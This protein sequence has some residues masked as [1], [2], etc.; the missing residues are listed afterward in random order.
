[1]RYFLL[2]AFFLLMLMGNTQPQ[3]KEYNCISFG[4]NAKQNFSMLDSVVGNYQ[5]FLI[6]E[7]HGVSAN[8]KIVME[9][10]PYLHEK[11]N[12]R[13]LLIE[14]GYTDAYLIN[15]YLATGDSF[16]LNPLFYYRYKDY[17]NFWRELYHFNQKMPKEKRITV[18]GI[19]FEYSRP[20]AFV[21]NSLITRG[22]KIPDEILPAIT[23]IMV[24]DDSLSEIGKRKFLLHLRKDVYAKQAIYEEYFGKS[25]AILKYIIDNNSFYASF[26]KRDKEMQNNFIKYH[27]D[28]KGNYL[29]IMGMFH[30]N[31]SKDQRYEFAYQLN[32]DIFS[33][34]KGKVLSF[35]CHY[36]NCHSHY[37]NELRDLSGGLLTYY[38]VF[39]KKEM[40]FFEE[41]ITA[42]KG[43]DI[44][45][46]DLLSPQNNTKNAAQHGRYLFYIRNQN[47]FEVYKKESP[48]NGK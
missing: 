26:Y 23:N 4:G 43:C 30:V 24:M 38:K 2:G 19:D 11:A 46:M 15:Y 48:K 45:L 44:F 35:N 18:V 36:E 28:L 9:M 6:G 31:A 1:M 32:N 3:M 25:F 14:F 37:R 12:V 20:L 16:Y 33:P 21:L 29:G 7:T 27:K 8:P 47:A 39:N 13:N 10:L 22:K 34:F 17:H 41:S 42:I 5:V 40:K